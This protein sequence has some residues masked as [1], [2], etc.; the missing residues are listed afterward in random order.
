[1]AWLSVRNSR[2]AGT[3]ALQCLCINTCDADVFSYFFAW[4]L[5][6]QPEVGA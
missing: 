3:Q 1:M 4:R 6:W 5:F 2:K